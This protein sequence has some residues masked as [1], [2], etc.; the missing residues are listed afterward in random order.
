MAL[1]VSKIAKPCPD[2]LELLYLFI[3]PFQ[4]TRRSLTDSE[5]FSLRLDS[6]YP[7]GVRK[8]FPVEGGRVKETICLMESLS[9]LH[10]AILLNFFYNK[11]FVRI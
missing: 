2:P 11:N 7:F 3:C 1:K 9:D 4:A 8:E 5:V 6:T 10:L